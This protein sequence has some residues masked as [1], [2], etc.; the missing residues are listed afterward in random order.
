LE[1]T[2]FDYGIMER[3]K[4]PIF[5]V[6]C[7]CGWS[8]VGSWLSLYE[9][10]EQDQDGDQNLT[11]G[12]CLLIDCKKSFISGKSGRQVACMGLKN[13][14]V[15]DTPDALLVTDLERSQEIKKIVEQ[16]KKTQKEELV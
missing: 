5:V 6:P 16:L 10:K 14:L 9:L 3:T 15:I 11:E 13:C 8:D 4:S 2:S 7:D 1:A 12:E